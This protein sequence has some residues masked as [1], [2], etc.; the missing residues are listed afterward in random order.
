MEEEFGRQRTPTASV[1]DRVQGKAAHEA[2]AKTTR[3]VR[4][5]FK[6]NATGEHFDVVEDG[7]LSRSPAT[8]SE[9]SAACLTRA[10][11]DHGLDF[12]VLGAY[13]YYPAIQ[14]DASG[15]L[16]A[17]FSE[18]S[19]SEYAGVWASGQ[20]TSDG[21]HTFRNPV[22]LQSG[23]N[24]YT[25]FANRWGDYSGAALDPSNT[26]VVWV[27]GEYARIEGGSEW[28]TNITAVQIQ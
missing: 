14:T 9:R 13:S 26:A 4:L 28:G 3:T 19:S 6:D 25:P 5:E 10:P 8:R 18:S 20:G 17:V 15:N 16:I 27:A 7:D 22:V 1:A 2:P 12:G 23:Q 21:L 24:S 11:G